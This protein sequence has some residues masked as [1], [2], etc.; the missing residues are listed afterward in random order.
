MEDVF[1]VQVRNKNIVNKIAMCCAAAWC[2]GAAGSSARC[3]RTGA[4]SIL[5]TWTPPLSVRSM[6]LLFFQIKENKN[7]VL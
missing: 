2:A 7:Y 6:A 5:F 4:P 1:G 3:A